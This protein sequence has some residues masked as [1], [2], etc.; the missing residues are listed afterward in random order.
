MCLLE[1]K[2]FFFFGGGGLKHE[3]VEVLLGSVIYLSIRMIPIM[4][5]SERNTKP[6]QLFLAGLPIRQAVK[7]RGQV[8]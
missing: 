8:G 4:A 5:N 1:G 2:V 3:G 7:T 6:D